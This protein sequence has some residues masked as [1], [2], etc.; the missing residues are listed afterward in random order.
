MTWKCVQFSLC[1]CVY[2][3]LNNV[4]ILA[5]YPQS[6]KCKKG[7]DWL[8]T[9]VDAKTISKNKVFRDWSIIYI[10]NT[11]HIYQTGI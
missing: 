8:K 11:N 5:I 2:S 10:W 3:Q 9:L 6:C 1:M 4:K 7:T